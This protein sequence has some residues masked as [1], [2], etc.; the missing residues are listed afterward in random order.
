MLLFCKLSALLYC[1]QHA[2]DADFGRAQV[3]DLVNFKLCIDFAAVFTNSAHFVRCDRIDAT[4]E[5]YELDELRVSLRV[6]YFAAPYMRE[7]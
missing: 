3:A 6:T 5:R 1:G 4:A 7:W 2:A